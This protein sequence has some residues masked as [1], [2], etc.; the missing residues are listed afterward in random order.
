VRRDATI[1]RQLVT[2]P[3]TARTRWLD[4]LYGS[5][6]AL[7][8][9]ALAVRSTAMIGAAIAAEWL[10]VR[11]TD[12]VPANS[13]SAL[14]P[15]Q[16]HEVLLVAMLLGGIVGLT[17]AFWV[18]EADA[19]GE[20]RSALTMAM[21]IIG[22]LALMVWLTSEHALSLVLLAAVTA[23]CTYP[24]VLGPRA[25]LA[26]ASV[27]MGAVVGFALHGAVPV[28]MLGWLAAEVGVG[29]GV[30]LFVR[31]LVFR[32]HPARALRR[33]VRTGMAR[34][35]TVAR[36]SLAAFEE[37]AGPDG[38]VSRRLR[39]QLVRLTEAVL[40][41]DA[42]LAVPG[43]L[44][45]DGSAQ[46]LHRQMFDIELRMG[47][48]ARFAQAMA[49]RDV[50]PE[51][52]TLVRHALRC[53][54]DGDHL[55]AAAAART[56]QRSLKDLPAGCPRV[57]VVVLHRFAGTMTSL[58]DAMTDRGDDDGSAGDSGPGSTTPVKLTS[59][60]LPGS[61]PA[62][63]QASAEAGPRRGDRIRLSAPTRGVIQMAVA[64]AVAAAA[65]SAVSERRVYWAL[66]AVLVIFIGVNN[67]REQ[68][69]KALHRAA[70]TLVGVVLGS[71]LARA[72]GSHTDWTVAV[73]L[74]AF[75]LGF[76]FLPVNYAFFVVG[77]TVAVSQLYS[78]MGELSNGLL[79]VRLEETVLG[80]LAATVAVLVVLPLRTHHAFQVA[81]RNHLAALSSL[82][83]HAVEQLCRAGTA[84]VSLRQ[85]IRAL[86]Q[87]HH[88]LLATA[89]PLR[90]R[91]FARSGPRVEESLRL[92]ESYRDYARNLAVDLEVADR[93]SPDG[94]SGLVAAGR[95]LTSSI[96][97]LR[98]AV[99]GQRG[100]TYRPSA[101]LFE[102]IE[103]Q[104][105]T[106]AGTLH[107]GQL[108]LRDLQRIDEIMAEFAAHEAL[109]SAE[110]GPADGRRR[111]LSGRPLDPCRRPPI[112]RIPRHS[113][114]AKAT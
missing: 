100:G 27:F 68:V 106:E 20:I 2:E 5:D 46:R 113:G 114:Q 62:S 16:H 39:S 67:T 11:C 88:I 13:R 51:Q 58:T 105:E 73:V 42:Q 22:G 37:G 52:A 76:Y 59:G 92:A 78:Q 17:S 38:R 85:D 80:A 111:P 1:L 72:V 14:V 75:L 9:A 10:F 21:P 43:S 87:A 71:V 112:Q 45:G 31:L 109:Q 41:V 107:D 25:L 55:G 4:R 7:S 19:R 30:C 79:L 57:D 54:A 64:A 86:D 15:Q 36:L 35:R 28:S 91:L 74:S 44:R 70:G 98:R 24:R 99:D 61:A 29:V 84:E 69:S 93:L 110:T 32:P 66:I 104:L 33:T 65:G 53:L 56:L 60:R 6:P 63:A 103:R 40:M 90:S 94:R 3:P 26:G 108:A 102:L 34:V 77:L 12:A 96:D 95:V 47:S 83:E 101:P 8:R 81:L 18:S 49:H 50:P 97:A 82:V 23:G 89:A 48:V